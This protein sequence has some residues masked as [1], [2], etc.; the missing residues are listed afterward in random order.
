M[1][2]TYFPE[3]SEGDY[4]SFRAIIHELMPTYKD[5]LHYIAKRVAHWSKTH[6]VIRV[7]MKPDSLSEYLRK[8]GQVADLNSLY[9]AA[10][11]FR[12]SPRAPHST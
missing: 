3:I 6:N 12:N 5:W 7:E 11:F 4:S 9:M 1:E 10:E 2:D 8:S